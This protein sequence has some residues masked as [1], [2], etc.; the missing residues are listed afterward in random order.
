M[1]L[2]LQLLTHT[3]N[4][5]RPL[6]FVGC[7]E[8]LF[9]HLFLELF[10]NGQC[11]RLMFF[12]KSGY[13]LFSCKSQRIAGM[14]RYKDPW[15]RVYTRILDKI[16]LTISAT[17]TFIVKR[18]SSIFFLEHNIG[19][20]ERTRKATA[21]YWASIAEISSPF[22]LENCRKLFFQHRLQTVPS[23]SKEPVFVFH[24]PNIFQKIFLLF[25]RIFQLFVSPFQLLLGI[26]QQQWNNV[27][28]ITKW[29]ARKLTG[30]C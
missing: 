8:N 7:E 20:Y 22:F 15:S 1:L 21:T 10:H 14:L 30:L 5:D 6:L 12:Y 18:S 26:V 13:E 3:H 23:C 9:P 17:K 11:L 25:L 29:W 4:F 16:I 19:R 28:V 24:K 27:V 2:W